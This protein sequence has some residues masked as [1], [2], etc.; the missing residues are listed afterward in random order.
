M[1][2]IAKVGVFLSG[3][4]CIFWTTIMGISNF[5]IPIFTSFIEAPGFGVL[6]M[7]LIKLAVTTAIGTFALTLEFMLFLCMYVIIDIME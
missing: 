1:A 7:A 3:V 4:G 5:F 6:F 2:T